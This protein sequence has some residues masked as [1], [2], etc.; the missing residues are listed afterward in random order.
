MD[1]GELVGGVFETGF[2]PAQITHLNLND[3]VVEGLRLLE[4]PAFSVQ[5]HPEAAPGPHDAAGLFTEFCELM[6][7][8]R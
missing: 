6:E 1:G 7:G 5:Y 3:G 2:G 4:A 8:A